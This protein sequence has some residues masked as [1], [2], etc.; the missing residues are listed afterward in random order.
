[1][2]HRSRI[3]YRTTC[4]DWLKTLA[5]LGVDAAGTVSK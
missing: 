1:V 4:R 2:L 3:E 5:A